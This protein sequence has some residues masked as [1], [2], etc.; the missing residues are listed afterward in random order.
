MGRFDD[1]PSRWFDE[2]A[3]ALVLYA[4]RWLGGGAEDAVQEAFIRVLQLP[5][6]PANS[7]A[8]L[9]RSVRQMALSQLRSEKRRAR[10]EQTT[11]MTQEWFEPDPD[12]RLDVQSAQEALKEL[13]PEQWE[14][15]ILRIWGHLGFQEIAEIVGSPLSTVHDQY[16][17]ALE[18]IRKKMEQPC[19]PNPMNP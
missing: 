19:H 8:W 11:A 10:R 18:A 7:R 1:N 16:R 14:L 12:Q 4:R 6:P 17:K 2:Y 13:P 15:V 9:F 5:R 3:P